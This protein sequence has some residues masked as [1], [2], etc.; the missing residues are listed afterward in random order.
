MS[1]D[2]VENPALD[3]EVTGDATIE[4]VQPSDYDVGSVDGSTA[5]VSSETFFR[6]QTTQT[7]VVLVDIPENVE[8]G[9][10]SLTATPQAESTEFGPTTATYE[11]T[12]AESSTDALASAA[13]ARATIASSYQE[14][15]ASLLYSEPWNETTETAMQDAFATAITDG[16]KGAIVGSTPGVS[17]VDDMQTSYDVA[18]GEYDGG[19]VGQIAAI[20]QHLT[21]E[22]HS[23]MDRDDVLRAGNSSGPLE[24]FET[25]TTAEREAWE[26]GDRDELEELLLRQ[27]AVLFDASF[28]SS[29]NPYA[30]HYDT[31]LYFEARDQ[32][33]AAR[34][35]V[36]FG[37]ESPLLAEYFESLETFA[38]DEH[39][40]IDTR[41]QLVRDPSP[42]AGTVSDRSSI[43]DELRG[44]ETGETTTVTF[45]V[46]NANGAGVTGDGYLSVSHSETL[47]IED[48]TAV[49]SDEPVTYHQTAPGE[50]AVNATGE[51]VTLD[52]PLLDVVDQ[53]DSGDHRAFEVTIQRE[54]EGEAW[55]SYRA[56]FD[57]FVVADGATPVEEQEAYAR[58]PQS[59]SVDQQGWPVHTL[60][61]A[62]TV[63][64]PHVAIDISETPQA[65]EQ[66]TLDASE[67][68]AD[69]DID[70]I[71]WTVDATGNGEVDEKFFGET[72]SVTFDTAG[73]KRLTATVTDELG[74]TA[75]A[76]TSIRVEDAELAATKTTL[77]FTANRSLPEPD[78][79]IE[80][81]APSNVA[82]PTW[83]I[84]TEG[85]ELESASSETFS[86]SVADAGTYDVT[87]SGT[88]DGNHIVETRTIHVATREDRVSSPSLQTAITSPSVV[89]D[90][91][92][93]DAT[94]S[95][96]PH[97]EREIDRFELRVDGTFVAER[98]DGTFEH[99][100]TE[101]GRYDVEITAIGSHG[102]EETVARTVSVGDVSRT[103][104]PA[105]HVTPNPPTA[106]EPV[107]FD[108]TESTADTPIVAYEWTFPDGE[109]VTG[110]T[111]ERTLASGSHTIELQIVDVDGR[112]ATVTERVRT[113]DYDPTDP[114][115][116]GYIDGTGTDEQDVVW[117]KSFERS[118]EY[119]TVSD[120]SVYVI[121][122]GDWHTAE[123]LYAYD[124]DGSERWNRSFS[125]SSS[126]A[127]TVGDSGTVYVSHTRGVQAFDDHGTEQ[128]DT[129]DLSCGAGAC[130]LYP[131]QAVATDDGVYTLGE[132]SEGTAL[133][134]LDPETGEIL[135]EQTL[136]D[137]ADYPDDALAVSG[138]SVY[139]SLPGEGLV[140]V[141]TDGE[142]NWRVSL[143]DPVT[144][145]VST[146][147]ET[148]LYTTDREMIGIDGE[149]GEERFRHDSQSR[150][151]P[152]VTPDGT[153]VLPHGTYYDDLQGTYG[154][155]I[156]DSDGDVQA[157]WRSETF[158]LNPNDEYD[159]V[160]Q[161]LV[162]Q[163]GLIRFASEFPRKADANHVI[164]LNGT[165]QSVDFVNVGTPTIGL[166]SDEQPVVVG[167][168]EMEALGEVPEPEPP[169]PADV[170]VPEPPT[171]SW[172]TDRYDQGNT[173]SAEQATPPRPIDS[174]WHFEVDRD[175][176]QGTM[177][178]E[179]AVA[180]DEL[181]I[182][183]LNRVYGADAYDGSVL[184]GVDSETGEIRWNAIDRGSDEYFVEDIQLTGETVVVE[185]RAGGSL[186]RHYMGIDVETGEQR[187]DTEIR[188]TEAG[189]KA[190]DETIY[191]RSSTQLRAV[192]AT[193]GE[194]MWGVSPDEE[195]LS[196]GGA[197]GPPLVTNETVF[198][199]GGCE[200]PASQ[201]RTGCVFA[202]DRSNGETR[203]IETVEH[204]FATTG[205]IPVIA[206]ESLYLTGDLGS[207]TDLVEFDAMTGDVLGN[208]SLGGVYGSPNPVVTD[209]TFI[210]TGGVFSQDDFSQQATVGFDS[211]PL[212]VGDLAIG[213]AD[214]EVVAYDVNNGDRLETV[215]H[216]SGDTAD[217]IEAVANGTV[218]T[219]NRGHNQ[220]VLA[221]DGP[222]E[223]GFEIGTESPSIDKPVTFEAVADGEAFGWDFTG[224]GEIDTTGSVVDHSFERSGS[225]D[226][227]LIADPDS[228][229]PQRHVQSVT[230]TEPID[231]SI[232]TNEPYPETTPVTVKMSASEST[233]TGGLDYDWT[234]DDGESLDCGVTCYVSVEDDEPITVSV[235]VTD[236]I[237]ATD[238]TT[239][240]LRPVDVGIE[241]TVDG[242]NRTDLHFDED[243]L[244]DEAIVVTPDENATLT[245]IDVT[246][247]DA[248]VDG[249][250]ITLTSS[251]EAT[252]TARLDVD[253]VAE[254]VPRSVDL[255]VHD[256]VS[257]TDQFEFD[258]DSRE[259]KVGLAIIQ[260]QL[261][262]MVRGIE[263]RI[264][265]LPSTIEYR[266]VE[267]S[268][269]RAG[270]AVFPNRIIVDTV[271][272][273]STLTDRYAGRTTEHELTHLAQYELG[274]ETRGEWNFLL[275][276]HATFEQETNHRYLIGEGRPDRQELLDW[277][278]TSTE[279]SQ[280]A[281][282][283][284]AFFVEY[285][286]QTFLEM[287]EH[288]EGDDMRARFH[289]ATGDSFDDFY[290]RWEGFSNDPGIDRQDVPYRVSFEY[291]DGELRSHSPPPSVDVSWDLTG[292]GEFDRTGKTI[293]WVPSE[294][295][296]Q[297]VTVAYERYGTTIEQTQQF[298]V[299]AADIDHGEFL[300]SNITASDPVSEG[301]RM[302]IEATVTNADDVSA[303]QVIELVSEDGTVLDETS[304]HL[305]G[306]TTE[307]VSFEW[308]TE[309]GDGGTSSL[310]VRTNDD[311]E[312]VLV[313]VFEL[314]I[315]PS[316]SVSDQT[317]YN[318]ET[319][320]FDASATEAFEDGD[321]V[322]ID[323][324]Q[325]DLGPEGT[326][327]TTDPVLEHQFEE[328]G[329]YTVAVSFVVGNVH[330]TYETNLAVE[331][332]DRPPSITDVTVEESLTND[333]ATIHA[334]V[335][336]VGA[337][338]ATI[339]SGLDAT[340]TSFTV[341]ET[342]G[343]SSGQVSVTI[344]R[345]AIVADGTYT[346][347]VSAEDELG[348]TATVEG[349]SV[350]FDTTPPE[351][352]AGI[353][354]GAHQEAT[355][356]IDASQPVLLNDIEIIADGDETIDRTPSNVPDRLEES[357]DGLEIPF[358]GGTVGGET[359]YTVSITGIDDA[360]N[361]GTT[362]LESTITSYQV[363]NGTAKLDERPYA[364]E[365]EGNETA[366]GDDLARTATITSSETP[367][368]GTTLDSATFADGFLDV[369]DI[370]LSETEL[371]EATLRLSLDELD[372]DLATEFE[373]T[374]LEIIRSGETQQSY[375]P[376]ATRYNQSTN[377]LVATV[378]GFSQFAIAGNDDSPPVIE[379][380]TADPSTEPDEGTQPVTVTFEYSPSIS[381]I[382]VAA[383]EITV[384]GTD[385]EYD[386]QIET[387]QAVVTLQPP[388]E[389]DVVSATL[390]LVDTGGNAVTATETIAVG[391]DDS[392]SG[393]GFP[394]IVGEDPSD[395]PTENG[396]DNSDEDEKPDEDSE[397][398][399][400]EGAEDTEDD[401]DQDNETN[402][403]ADTVDEDDQDEADSTSTSDSTGDESIP[404]FGAEA[405][406][407]A[408]LVTIFAFRRQHGGGE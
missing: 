309:R 251:G 311:T 250:S 170:G 161:P 142:E 315:E 200:V 408:L 375:E 46:E 262:S 264:G 183:G 16:T 399:D 18:T 360:G 265:D 127:P 191:L 129:S 388:E 267:D 299:D 256:Y 243:V 134:A 26:A 274:M 167:H 177:P 402:A 281:D 271:R 389:G 83:S 280:S 249:D 158:V 316:L 407:V 263:Q 362:T 376:I 96:H 21:N 383:T 23:R 221:F 55:L 252:I 76:E 277:D 210:T 178:I 351:L 6:P 294:Y 48:V 155:D 70:A 182:V 89:T 43:E 332:D 29:G 86:V 223:P 65:G 320:T 112:T 13:D 395:D 248:D 133:F 102:N 147:D 143:P 54:A 180:S 15:Y 27:Q 138:D 357:S 207:S 257:E 364:I 211:Q 339:D 130:F 374:D 307:T 8:S 92:E 384:E 47:S 187:W 330:D 335:E 385:Q 285:D 324:Y 150:A 145:P 172:P 378:D 181:T 313:D 80:F 205:P 152:S 25:L 148:V 344:D 69:A 398:A 268:G 310:T 41:L 292:D 124:S 105:I 289:S 237:G 334:T 79:D 160:E 348:N 82:D 51:N 179:S 391:E 62:D 356:S 78:D 39:R 397:E 157:E 312:T 202:V 135:W 253:G 40:Q 354:D 12:S 365:L 278:G 368:A 10:F 156:L 290:D 206:D 72:T 104:S 295:G 125:Q 111:V 231:A 319:V 218:V 346:P 269:D 387:D 189:F 235:A 328:A 73:T 44:L 122:S 116:T 228:E 359:T 22:L 333:T 240:E 171:D 393:G 194:T 128:W 308:A 2:R 60:S 63:D 381:D 404:G 260:P 119:R 195:R 296:E 97:P 224:D 396:Q 33:D 103:P 203:W 94:N 369:S 212:A 197:V 361:V 32:K 56:A 220:S 215:A 380:V 238:T 347:F 163:D 192:N 140:S 239:F 345:D 118:T 136:A 241:L 372:A 199:A 146:P 370:G 394:P 270:Y 329:N 306:G 123:R 283:V 317:P 121:T 98:A 198:S 273:S 261:D 304:L 132:T 149:T 355:L 88:V 52:D 42:M 363:D 331:H 386:A 245:D 4:T 201:R 37:S 327:T 233:G 236:E 71:E 166:L 11:I 234:R 222:T 204:R 75:S 279:Y 67:T 174:S 358:E 141:G 20:N 137:Q 95:T 5:T 169:E 14:S 36:G 99:A 68:T 35:S 322:A 165:S 188:H 126:A 176:G 276:G 3:F 77:S 293:D 151:P 225:H 114:A 266:A 350:Q 100:V 50:Q 390:T 74:H 1:D 17:T 162:T 337:D 219:L 301:D 164:D 226:V 81:D 338:V 217:E 321:D 214:G 53:Y 323:S 286:R 371:E 144:H 341:S 59:G 61:T 272:G 403:S 31:S 38:R 159:I 185:Y 314:V 131:T 246:G 109:T 66:V 340:F 254:P 288:S 85:T 110:D 90:P 232:E 7:A 58:Y 139:V 336:S 190:V 392:G 326:V 373:P 108:G 45:T 87:L 117:T 106:G 406:A 242:A 107:T 34:S 186:S 400:L 298:T 193:T 303:S 213:T 227:F 291:V 208:E 216:E 382:D 342:V 302:D 349:E 287:V 115:R 244:T 297:T 325:W 168:G 24:T 255:T 57:P 113:S 209:S 230:V 259:S 367:P 9:S 64:P 343:E 405:A 247:I 275:E 196:F 93:I 184:F 305:D 30:S 282:F 173:G 353:D 379:S 28:Q 366:I 101:D 19:T 377:E 153:I 318:T 91:I 49:D 401:V 229:D 120:R 154:I 175:D 300:V 258:A 284:S 84:A 352:Q